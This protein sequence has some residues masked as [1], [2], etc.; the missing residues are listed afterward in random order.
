[1]ENLSECKNLSNL[2]RI[3][4]DILQLHADLGISAHPA[5]TCS[6]HLYVLTLT[7]WSDLKVSYIM[8]LYIG[9]NK[10]DISTLFFLCVS[11]KFIA[12]LGFTL[13]IQFTLLWKQVWNVGA[14][15][16]WNVSLYEIH[17]NPYKI[18]MYSILIT[19][20]LFYPMWS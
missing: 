14:Q 5:V 6:T 13:C 18:N 20:I 3:A 12:G 11:L 4:N 8:L 7:K 2:Q 17:V 9:E 15:M 1:M 10:D 16:L 19:V